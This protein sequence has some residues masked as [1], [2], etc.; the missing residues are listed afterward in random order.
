MNGK[1]IFHLQQ[2]KTLCQLM[3]YIKAKYTW[4]MIRSYCVDVIKHKEPT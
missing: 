4:N 1:Q 3:V 2:Q